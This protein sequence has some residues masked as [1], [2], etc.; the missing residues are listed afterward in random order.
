MKGL[1]TCTRSPVDRLRVSG[2]IAMQSR[3]EPLA[4]SPSKRAAR[5]PWRYLGAPL[6]R[7]RL[8]L[9]LLLW[10]ATATAQVPGD[11]NC[12]GGTDGAD[13][14][15]LSHALFTAADQRCPGADA[16]A[17]GAL[18]AADAT[19]L[20]V[21]VSQGPRVTFIGLVGSDG[22]PLP[23]LGDIRGTPVFFRNSG[24][25][26]RLVVESRR[27]PGGV[28]PGT[29]V[30]ASGTPATRPD[31]QV[32]SAAPLG[33]G[34]ISVCDEAGGVPGVDPP[35]FG[36]AA[37]VSA[38]LN[39]LGC[40]FTVA[41]AN[42]SACTV[43]VFGT[44]HFV[45]P[46]TEVQYCL[47]VRRS[48][49]FA[50]GE[51]LVAV[52]VR[53]TLAALGP[54]ATLLVRVGPGPVPPTFT[55]QPTA[56]ATHTR[57]PTP[58]TTATATATRTRTAPRVTSTPLPTTP[59]TTPS[60]TP[61]PT[62]TPSP[63]PVPPTATATAAQGPVVTFV[64]LTDQGDALVEPSGS[65]VGVPVYRQLVGT[66]FQLVV[67]GKPG[68]NGLPVGRNAYEPVVCPGSGDGAAAADPLA[69]P[70][71]QIQV[72][73]D[74][75][76]GS[77]AVCDDSGPTAGGVPG[78][79]PPSFAPTTTAIAA[80]NDLGCR[81]VDGNGI[82]CA[83]PERDSCV[84]FDTREGYVDPNST[85]QFCG[86]VTSWFAFPAGDTTVTV[87]LQDIEGN[88]GPATQL[89][90]RIGAGTHTPTRT[91]TPT[92]SAT[93]A[94][95]TATATPTPPPTATPPLGPVVTF[96][97]LAGG[98]GTLLEPPGTPGAVPVY[99]RLAGSGFRLV[100]EGR[101]GPSGSAVG[102]S[103]DDSAQLTFP[104][105]QIVVSRL[106]GD[107]ST[108]V[109]DAAGGVPATDPPTFDPVQPIID[110]VN[111]LACRFRDRNHNPG[112]VTVADE[113][114]VKIPPTDDYGFA[115]PDSSVQFCAQVA[116]A[117][118]FPVGDTLVTARLRD[119]DGHTGAATSIIVRVAADEA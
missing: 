99:D 101:P 79:D 70:D 37:A 34:S 80:A 106:L 15:A 7:A 67:E 47:E 4:P 13:L 22:V 44:P 89:I 96:L 1:S 28:Q 91:A 81:F 86:R 38:A 115:R 100:V 111:D 17:D 25:S 19:A 105:L 76:N 55:P 10:V 57:T 50:E 32:L 40:H 88:P 116:P 85:V 27:G 114:C 87:R 2:N 95:P 41:T 63:T 39:D 73:R 107:G 24:S 43:D 56:T 18:T 30:F 119:R 69:F 98:D 45:D 35:T 113:S 16:N 117:F 78:V 61:P 53:D 23:S 51:T 93:R 59:R 97:G 84:L 65:V 33:D 66:G 48:L 104:D 103:A 29:T 52:Q 118:R 11:A 31:L 68:A 83:R 3:V 64:G 20:V 12:D 54:I 110:A 5:I 36:P 14:A 60:R 94:P 42:P 58:R 90:V 49:Q 108:A 26:F 74:L 9:I 109:C 77:A 72:T 21:R 92:P 62:A 46:T 102:E 112:A 8:A 71:L 75:G 6:R 82:P